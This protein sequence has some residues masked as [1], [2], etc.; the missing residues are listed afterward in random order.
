M[1]FPPGSRW[2]ETGHRHSLLGLNIQNIF[3]D[4]LALNRHTILKNRTP[5]N[6]DG[7]MKIMNRMSFVK[8]PT[9]AG[10]SL[11]PDLAIA[12]K[13]KNSAQFEG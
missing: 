2:L 8:V 13:K 1:Q 10:L 6:S 4:G 5:V 3:I 7:A 9:K 11:P 12:I